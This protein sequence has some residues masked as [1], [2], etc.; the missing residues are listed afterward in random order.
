MPREDRAGFTLVELLAVIA[1][2]GLLMA[3]LL[4]AV[5]GVRESARR[6][7]C[8]NNMRQFAIAIQAYHQSNGTF[9]SA[10]ISEKPD[11]RGSNANN[12]WTVLV[13]PFI[14]LQSLADTYDSTAGFRGTGY[15]AVN[16]T[17][18]RTRM[19]LYECPSDTAGSTRDTP[20][21][22]TA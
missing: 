6:L 5:Q 14:E 18:F 7:H 10:S 3:L 21:P 9:P 20:A 2:I 19:P 13:W 16:G 15:D 22:T 8:G 17:I 11:A 4:P 1:I 12:N